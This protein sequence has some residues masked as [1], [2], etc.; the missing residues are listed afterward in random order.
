MHVLSLAFTFWQK[1]VLLFFSEKSLKNPEIELWPLG[2][3][4]FMILKRNYI[5]L[6][7]IYNIK[8]YVYLIPKGVTL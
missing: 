1:A 2:H 3:L 8:A 7:N 4:Y 5:N 6:D